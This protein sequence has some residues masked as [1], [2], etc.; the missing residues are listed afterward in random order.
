MSGELDNGCQVNRIMGV[1]ITGQWVSG[2]LDNGCPVSGELDNGCL[3]N[4]TMGVR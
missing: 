2:E 3:V 1:T 4:W